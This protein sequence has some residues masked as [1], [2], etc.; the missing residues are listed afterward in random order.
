MGKT[1]GSMTPRR[2][3][4]WQVWVC[5][6]CGRTSEVRYGF[7]ATTSSGWSDACDE[8]AVLD[9]HDGYRAHRL[10]PYDQLPG[11]G[12]DEARHG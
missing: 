5:T 11:H 7:D 8:S 6:K 3:P 2:A 10:P 4:D 1:T 12:D 9:W